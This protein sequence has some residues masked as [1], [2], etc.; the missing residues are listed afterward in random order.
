VKHCK[1]GFTLVEVML[2]VVVSGIVLLMSHQFL[3]AALDA[4]KRI[5]VARDNADRAVNRIQWLREAFGELVVGGDSLGSFLGMADHVAFSSALLTSNGWPERTQVS[6]GVLGDG[7]LVAVLSDRDTLILDEHVGAIS[8]DYL[9]E[10]G[11]A[12]R[13]VHEWHSP[14][15]APLAVRIRLSRWMPAARRAS[16]DTLLFLIGERG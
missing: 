5:A 12:A 10:F 9:F 11:E 4:S 7:R 14:S 15:T 6:L 1:A 2:A 3:T 8:F 16:T 13:W